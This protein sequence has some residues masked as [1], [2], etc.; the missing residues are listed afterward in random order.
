MSKL[1]KTQYSTTLAEKEWPS[2]R[3]EHMLTK[4]DIM[5]YLQ[6]SMKRG[7]TCQNLTFT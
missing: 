1:S 7:E 5:D 4:L 3:I 2:D 6:T